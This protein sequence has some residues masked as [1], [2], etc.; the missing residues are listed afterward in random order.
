VT[1]FHEKLQKI[2]EKI[3]TAIISKGVEV[4]ENAT[5]SDMATKIE[6]IKV[7]KVSKRKEKENA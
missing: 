7:S 2:K 1:K 4:P 3:R 5:L 6:E